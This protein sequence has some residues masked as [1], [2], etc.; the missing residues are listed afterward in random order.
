M[1]GDWERGYRG[2]RGSA[3]VSQSHCHCVCYVCI[4]L[5][6]GGV[7]GEG[8]QRGAGLSTRVSEPLPLCVLC[9]YRAGDRKCM[10]TGRGGTEGSGA[11]H[12]SQS[13]F[14]CQR[15]DEERT[16][17]GQQPCRPRSAV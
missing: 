16:V 11:Q 4:W 13:H 14:L 1:Y 9:M 6:I 3:L 15:S 10:G 5:G 7:W 8:I 2:G 17:S 12:S